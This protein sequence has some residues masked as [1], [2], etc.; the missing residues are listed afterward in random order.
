LRIP[1]FIAK[2]DNPESFRQGLLALPNVDDDGFTAI[3]PAA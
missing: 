1:D 3:S 2:R